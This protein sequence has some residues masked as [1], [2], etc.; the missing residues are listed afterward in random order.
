MVCCK[1]K[2]TLTH[3]SKLTVFNYS[4]LVVQLFSYIMLYKTLSLDPKNFKKREK[5]KEKF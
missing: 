4:Y 5:T 2:L 1:K 3:S